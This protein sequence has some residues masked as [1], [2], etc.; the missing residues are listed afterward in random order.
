VDVSA[1]K[2]QADGAV[3]IE[4]TFGSRP[5]SRYRIQDAEVISEQLAG[6]LAEKDAG[7]YGGRVVIPESTTL[8][9]YG[10]D[11]EAIFQAMEKFLKDH[12]ICAG[13]TVG[14]RQAGKMREVVIPQPVN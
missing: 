2:P 1:M 7:F 11:A 3:L 9:F 13:A 5:G 12:L 14:I 8:W 10:A 6:I 4:L